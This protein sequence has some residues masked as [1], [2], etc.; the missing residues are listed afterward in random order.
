MTNIK[1]HQHDWT[2]LPEL[3]YYMA[4]CERC[5]KVM[6]NRDGKIIGTYLQVIKQLKKA[7]ITID[8][9]GNEIKE[10]K[11]GIQNTNQKI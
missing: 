6:N 1:K 7:G 11:N 9:Y 10:V 8:I 4:Y 3:P 2:W 5:G